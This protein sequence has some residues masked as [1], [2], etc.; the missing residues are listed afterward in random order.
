MVNNWTDSL[1][2]LELNLGRLGVLDTARG[3][4]ARDIPALQSCQATVAM[5]MLLPDLESIPFKYGKLNPLR[6]SVP[7]SGKVEGNLFSFRRNL[8]ARKNLRISSPIT[9]CDFVFNQTRKI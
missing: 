1:L 7:K 5:E 2:V 3:S 4:T 6:L 9:S 8:C